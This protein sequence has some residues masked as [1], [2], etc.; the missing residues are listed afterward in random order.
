MS[1]L[2]HQTIGADEGFYTYCSFTL[3]VTVTGIPVASLLSQAWLTVK[4]NKTDTDA[5]AV[6]QKNI[7]SSLVA[8]VGQ[9]SDTGATDTIGEL[10]F[11]FT[12]AQN[13][14]LTAE[15]K[16]WFDIKIQ[17]NSGEVLPLIEDSTLTP[18]AAI[19]RDYT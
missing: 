6:M 16:Y 7:T 8:G 9:I 12:G 18:G 5:N 1:V 15:H 3:V 17:Y 2:R 19:T 10:T 13:G 14:A 11:L 4:T